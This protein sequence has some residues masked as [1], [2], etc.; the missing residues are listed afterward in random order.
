MSAPALFNGFCGGGEA[1]RQVCS[2]SS[3]PCQNTPVCGALSQPV[4][5]AGIRLKDIDNLLSFV[6]TKFC[7]SFRKSYLLFFSLQ[8]S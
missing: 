8:A 1:G 6:E 2:L 3:W 4:E 7:E 5:G